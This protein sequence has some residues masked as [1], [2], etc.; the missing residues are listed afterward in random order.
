[1]RK[2]ESTTVEISK[3]TRD[4][5]KKAIGKGQKLKVWVD[6]ILNSFCDY[7]SKNGFKEDVINKVIGGENE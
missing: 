5:V 2:T 7:T 4:R 1:M 6:A 3:K